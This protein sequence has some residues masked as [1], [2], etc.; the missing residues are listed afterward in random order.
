MNKVLCIW[1]LI[2]SLWLAPACSPNYRDSNDKAVEKLRQQLISE[3]FGE[4]Y[5]GSSSITRAQLSQDD[6]VEKMKDA[7]TI[8]K[9][10]DPE[11]S[12]KKVEGSPEPA[13]YR[14]DN[15]SSLNLEKNGRKINI[16]LDWNSPFHLCGML[17]GGDIP[18]GGL[19]VFRNCD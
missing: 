8:L 6:F 15:W 5:E 10:V 13:V 3:K 16:Q 9:E 19:R 2:A 14:D 11:L 17:I 1:I 12:W 4:I 7:A 18:E